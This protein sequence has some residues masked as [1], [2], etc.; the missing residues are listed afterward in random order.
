MQAYLL[1][2]R[3][4]PLQPNVLGLFLLTVILENVRAHWAN[5]PYYYLQLLL[6]IPL[7]ID[8]GTIDLVS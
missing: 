2:T 4:P 7:Q 1:T 3:P 8:L 6:R 5:F